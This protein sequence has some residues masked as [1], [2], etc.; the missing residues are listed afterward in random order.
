MFNN[1]LYEHKFH[2]KRKILKE[3]LELS[4]ICS[5]FAPLLRLKQP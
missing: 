3:N 5:I 2:Y 1:I 4:K